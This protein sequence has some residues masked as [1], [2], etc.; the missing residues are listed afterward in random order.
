[1]DLLEEKERRKQ[2]RKLYDLYPDNG[3]LRRELYGK[4]LQFFAAGSSAEGVERCM[5]AANRV[6][7]TWGVGAYET[8]LHLTGRYPDWWEG[9]R[10]SR[11][12]S[13]WVAGDTKLTTRDIIQHALLGV[14]GEG[15]EGEL[16]TG[17][18]PGDCIKGKPSSMTG[19]PGAVDTCA[20][21]HVSGG[22]SILGFKSYDQ[23]RRTF[24]GTKKDLVWLDEE[25]GIDVYEEAMLRLTATSPGDENGLMLC[26]FTPLLGL[27]AVALKFLPDLAPNVE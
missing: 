21:K 1:M 2:R 25:P 7:K 12:I 9:R 3:P 24:Q 22:T 8:T 19:I 17:M 20:V 16:G 10:F 14:G 5:M 27:S 26:T 4:H 11:P 6:G 18:I 15:G 13:A 23:G